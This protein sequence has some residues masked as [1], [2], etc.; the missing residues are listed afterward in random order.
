MSNIA[1]SS[2]RHASRQYAKQLSSAGLV[3]A[4]A[5]SRLIPTS[6]KISK[7]G[8]VSETKKDSAQVNV[9]TAIRADPKVFFAETGKLPDNQPMQGTINTDVI[10]SPIA[11]ML[12]P[13]C[14]ML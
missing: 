5:V 1:A 4:A 11:S 6:P 3:R 7:C 9:D 2:L 12:D 14:C 10:T 8:Y 13:K